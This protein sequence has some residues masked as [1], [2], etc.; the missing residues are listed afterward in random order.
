MGDLLIT[1]VP[2]LLLSCYYYGA[3]AFVLTAVSVVSCVGFE[4]L[5]RK[6]LRLPRSVGDLS[7]MATGV[8]LAFNL[9]ATAPVWFP[10]VGAFF[11][12]VIVKQLF[13]GL[14]RNIFNPALAAVVFLTVS[15]PGV[16]SSFPLPF[17]PL[18]AFATPV[19]FETGRTALSALRAGSMPDNTLLEMFLGSRPGYLG[20]CAVIV[21]L[22]AA[23][24][25]LYRRIISWAIPA[26]FVGTVAAAAAIFPRCPSGRLDSVLFEVMSG[27]LLFIA[28]FVATDPV[29]SPVTTV[30]RLL[31]GF[32]CGLLTVLLRYFGIYPEG[33]CF[34]V[35]LMN[36]FVLAMDR[37]A[38]KLKV[39]GGTLQY[40]EE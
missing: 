20:A 7:A 11:A 27:S 28:L 29:T 39:K 24:Y 26:A 22:A 34:A 14:G 30:G 33:A 12:V 3:R 4:A 13:G 36:P 8:I 23:L 38:W 18:P 17:N 6:M 16:M 40:V 32:C 5:Y 31:Y 19:H 37:L 35:L 2:I 21:M 1:M 15:W 25:L 10:V 9:P